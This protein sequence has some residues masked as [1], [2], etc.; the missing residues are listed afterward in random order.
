M[1]AEHDNNYQN[2]QYPKI[3]AVFF[4]QKQMWDKVK[5]IE[6]KQQYSNYPLVV[7]VIIEME[8]TFVK[9]NEGGSNKKTPNDTVN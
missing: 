2:K 4:L 1:S 9:L 7:K 8:W 6:I 5:V 3:V